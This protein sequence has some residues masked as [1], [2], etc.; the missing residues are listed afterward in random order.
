MNRVEF[1]MKPTRADYQ[2]AMVRRFLI[3]RVFRIYLVSHIVTI[4]V[5]GVLSCFA[6]EGSKYEG[7]IVSLGGLALIA[8]AIPFAFFLGL[9]KKVSDSAWEDEEILHYL[10]A[11]GYGSKSKTCLSFVVEVKF[12]CCLPRRR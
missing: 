10:D 1:H 3:S 2:G 9:G 7:V 12:R 4:L 6:A 5:L 8:L 11:Q